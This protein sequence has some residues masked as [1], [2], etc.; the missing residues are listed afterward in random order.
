MTDQALQE[1]L[2]GVTSDLFKAVMGSVCT[3]VTVVT[4]FDGERPH[5]TTVSA[6]SSLSLT[7]PMVLV[8]LDEKSDLLAMLHSSSRFGINILSHAQDGLAGQFAT[9]GGDKFAGVDWAPRAGAPHILNSACWFSCEVAS[10]VSGGDHTIVLGNVIETDYL[11]HAPLTYH[12][13]SFGTHAAL[14]E[15]AS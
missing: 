11:D 2:S 13:R 7:P 8:A 4:A 12:R 15:R 10:L 5:G 14:P 1:A 9:K 3:P 6:F